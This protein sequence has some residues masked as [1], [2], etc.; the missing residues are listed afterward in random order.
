MEVESHYENH[1]ANYYSWIYG[2]FDTKVNE[3]QK[4]FEIHNIKPTMSEVA[5]D[6]GAGSGFQSVPLAKSGFKV[7]AVDFS[8]KLLNELRT[9]SKNLNV[10]I[11]ENDISNF[12]SYSNRNPELIVCMGDTLTHL[13]SL[14][15]VRDLIKN[16]YRELSANGRLI[17]SFR[18]ITIELKEE[19]RFIPV[20]SDDSR[21]FI[22]FLEYYLEYVKVF[23]IVY[24]HENGKWLQKISS[25]KKIKISQETIKQYIKE[26]GFDVEFFD[27][28][29]GL[30]TLIAKK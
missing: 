15:S 14:N 20:R 4:F 21:I 3:Y 8:K 7:I 10:E 23:D 16:S 19:E 12:D 29:N 1:L 22:C 24:E 2:G 6:L 26:A 17:L 13:G 30:V 25:Y 18:D 5:I 27:V 28:K 11:I 9:K